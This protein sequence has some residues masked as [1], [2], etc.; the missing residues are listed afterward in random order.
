MVYVYMIK[1]KLKTPKYNIISSSKLTRLFL[2]PNISV[3]RIDIIII[4][5]GTYLTFQT[6]NRR[7]LL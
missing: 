1:K 7:K 6:T 2:K 5:F 3:C 4:C